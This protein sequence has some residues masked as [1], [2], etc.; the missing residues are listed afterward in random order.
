MSIG[1]LAS[2]L[3][4]AA[5]LAVVF[6]VA[7][8]RLR[9]ARAGGAVG[10]TDDAWKSGALYRGAMHAVDKGVLLVDRSGVVSDANQAA[11]DLFQATD[12]ESV[13]G[14]KL[15]QLGFACESSEE[16]GSFVFEALRQGRRFGAIALTIRLDDGSLRSVDASASPVR[17][18]GCD[19][20]VAAVVTVVDV[21]GRRQAEQLLYDAH[22]NL[23]QAIDASEAHA[24][25]AKQASAA[26]SEFLANMSHEIRT[27]LNG[28]LGVTE[29]VLDTPLS[30]DQRRYLRLVKAS[31]LTLLGLLNDILDISKI[32]AG[33]MDLEEIDFDPAELVRKIGE[34]LSVKGG[35]K[36]VMFAFWIDNALPR[37]VRGDPARLRQILMNIV[38]NAI[39]FTERGSVRVEAR[40]VEVEAGWDLEIA[41]IDSGVGIPADRI[42]ALF[43]PFT[44]ADG[45]TTRRFGGTGLGLA[46]SRKL[47]RM[48]GGDVTVESVVGKGS[49]FRVRVRL[50]LPVGT[51]P[52]DAL[53]VPESVSEFVTG[54]IALGMEVEST[55]ES[56]PSGSHRVL[57]VEDNAV[58]QIVARRGLEGMGVSVDIAHNGRHGLELL[59]K[60]RYDMVFMDCQMPELDGFEATRLLRAGEDGVLDPTVPVVAMTAHALKG[61]RERCIDAG[62]DDYLTKP[63]SLRDLRG[64]VRRWIPHF[65]PPAPI[66][67]HDSDPSVVGGSIFD[68]KALL[69][70]VMNDP[71]V[72]REAIQVF[73]EETPARVESLRRA[74]T[75]GQVSVQ[76]ELLHKI[77]G[78]GA[79][80]GCAMLAGCA[81]DLEKWVAGAGASDEG[82]ALMQ[83]FLATWNESRSRLQAF[84]NRSASSGSG[85]G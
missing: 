58:N 71:E 14:R 40:A 65:N 63:L 1:F 27:P 43:E 57:V 64:K 53:S 67:M 24:R 45:S 70:R 15:E 6:A 48:M 55:L 79:N 82:N 18:P 54:A 56:P 25:E 85:Q 61:D 31:G 66:R 8:A 72:A 34:L 7:L 83:A 62:M 29:I 4:I 81:R 9:V 52:M 39:K 60:N 37:L 26:K 76:L 51:Q 16:C 77:E 28:I 80:L 17:L 73:L 74:L 13:R 2:V 23:L 50:G 12:L 42:G 35:D 11:L 10:E 22:H 33:R 41:V 49:T 78:S 30:P 5:L 47:A 84:L 59:A 3:A 21:T 19:S 46:I 44:Q 36:G 20:P 32:E 68:E 69:E 75:D 38:G